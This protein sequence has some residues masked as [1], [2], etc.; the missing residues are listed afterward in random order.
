VVLYITHAEERAMS[1][2]S[3]SSSD[4]EEWGS[5]NFTPLFGGALPYGAY[6]VNDQRSIKIETAN[7]HDVPSNL[8]ATDIWGGALAAA[9]Y[10]KENRGTIVNKTVIEFGAAGSLPSL[11]A[12]AL[13]AHFLCCTDYPNDALI[14]SI[15]KQF[16][17]NG[18]S[19]ARGK[20]FECKG[21]LWGSDTKQLLDLIQT[22]NDTEK[23]FYDV[24]ILAELLW[25]DT[26]LQ[27]ES[28]LT[29]VD[30][31]LAQDGSV[32]VAHTHHNVGE[33]HLDMEF[34]KRASSQFSFDVRTV[35][36]RHDLVY[37][38]SSEDDVSPV[39]LRVMTRAKGA[40]GSIC[41]EPAAT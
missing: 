38:D 4:D 8:F 33:E 6:V 9:D 3:S 12:L 41:L 7:F 23:R 28:L 25:N 36:V 40:K 2:G 22:N 14:K 30:S 17:S 11:V 15:N 27:H 19:E 32:Y 37:I 10:F 35:K 21:H 31:V 39:Y 29:S 34:F 16:D 20:S 18:F 24:V 5:V 13:G 26:Y 1:S